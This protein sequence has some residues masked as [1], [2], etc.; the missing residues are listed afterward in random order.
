MKIFKLFISEIVQNSK[1]SSVRIQNPR[2]ERPECFR[3]LSV[4]QKPGVLVTFLS[5]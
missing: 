2:P 5:Q 4:E 3:I 1:H